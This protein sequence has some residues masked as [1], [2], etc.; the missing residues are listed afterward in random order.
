MN[1]AEDQHYQS[2]CEGV[3]QL[4]VRHSAASSAGL[5][6][7]VLAHA[8]SD[9]TVPNLLLKMRGQPPAGRVHYQV[10]LYFYQS[11]TN[12]ASG[13]NG[14]QGRLDPHRLLRM[15][16]TSPQNTWSRFRN[17]LLWAAGPLPPS[18]HGERLTTRDSGYRRIT[19]DIPIPETPCHTYILCLVRTDVRPYGR[20]AFVCFAMRGFFL[21]G[22]L[23]ACFII[24]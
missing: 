11:R 24:H 13:D 5:F 17:F 12:L 18:L 3:T 2:L 23:I 8:T 9:L 21:E 16:Q 4:S 19:L 10:Q 1:V 22:R 6:P 20:T 15:R 14:L 7:G